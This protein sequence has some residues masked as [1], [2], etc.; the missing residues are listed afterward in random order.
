MGKEVD[1]IPFWLMRQAGRYL[2]EYRGLREK[3]SFLSLCKTSELIVEVTLQPIQ[4]FEMDAAILFS[5][6][7]LPLA[8]MGVGLQ[9]DDRLGPRLEWK[10]DAKGSWSRLQLPTFEQ[11]FSFLADAIRQ[12]RRK[13]SGRA[14]LVGFSGAPFTLLSY[15]VEGGSSRDL[16]ATKTFMFQEPA[17]YHA[18]M[19]RL[20]EMVEGY[21]GFQVRAGGQA[22]Q[23]FDTWAGVLALRDYREFV[24]PYT[25]KILKSLGSSFP[26]IPTILF[27]LGASTLLEEMAESGARVLSLDWRIE[28]GKARALLGPGRPVQ[29]NLDPLALFQPLQRI[30]DAVN[31]MLGKGSV[32]P[33]YI[34]NLGHGMH[35]KTPLEHVEKLVE[36]L[37]NQPERPPGARVA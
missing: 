16:A 32:F 26:E 1:R 8:S 25:Q 34:F 19:E 33:G 23:L 21:L 35:P 22:L 5:D 20:T 3:H 7:L 11:E 9:F 2:P 29:G 10:R 27:S 31:E 12:L 37:R 17:P 6:I 18:L 30:E 36:T 13:L 15:L 4:R 14:A 28:M 24:L